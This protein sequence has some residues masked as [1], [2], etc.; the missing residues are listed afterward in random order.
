[1]THLHFLP[2][3]KLTLEFQGYRGKGAILQVWSQSLRWRWPTQRFIV[4]TEND[5]THPGKNA[6]RGS[7]RW[8]GSTLEELFCPPSLD[9]VYSLYVCGCKLLLTWLSEVSISS[10][11]SVFDHQ[12][13]V[14][15][16][17]LFSLCFSG[18]SADAGRRDWK[19]H[20]AAE[21]SQGRRKEE[22]TQ[23]WRGHK[24]PR[25]SLGTS[26]LPF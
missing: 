4:T 19:A 22:V 9:T 15:R 20:K 3:F 8:F 2:L 26:T 21:G 16:H 6:T 11:L 23:L 18:E 5:R 25:T 14:R 7:S 1:M 10:L 17:W 13:L 12:S 24:W